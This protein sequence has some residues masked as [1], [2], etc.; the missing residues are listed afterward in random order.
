MGPST[1]SLVATCF[2]NCELSQ[3]E[4]EYF[5]QKLSLS[6]EGHSTLKYF[7]PLNTIEVKV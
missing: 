5:L 7:N 2:D 6:S 3:R 1:A 4:W